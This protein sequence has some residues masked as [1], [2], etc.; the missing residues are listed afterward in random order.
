MYISFHFQSLLY[1]HKLNSF[2]YYKESCVT[3]SAKINHLAY[4]VK[5]E[6]IIPAESAFVGDHN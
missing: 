6:I 2:Y 5:N 4:V 3:P 1:R